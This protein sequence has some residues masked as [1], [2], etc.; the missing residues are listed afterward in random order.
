MRRLASVFADA[1]A[2]YKLAAL[3]RRADAVEVEVGLLHEQI[4]SY[5]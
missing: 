1:V 2:A 5:W 4:R 3:K